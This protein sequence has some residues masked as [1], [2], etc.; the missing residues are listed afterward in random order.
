MFSVYGLGLR[1]QR[2]ELRFREATFAAGVE[3]A[4]AGAGVWE[5][6]CFLDAVLSNSG[7]SLRIT[8]YNFGFR[9]SGVGCRVKKV[10]DVGFGPRVIGFSIT[11]RSSS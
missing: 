7:V 5:L 8:I 2:L 9:V 4:L 6:R 3:A 10:Q 1:V 11:R